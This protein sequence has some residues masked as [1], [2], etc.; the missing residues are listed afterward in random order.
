VPSTCVSCPLCDNEPAAAGDDETTSSSDVGLMSLPVSTD[1]ERSS[2]IT[3]SSSSASRRSMPAN[4]NTVIMF[5]L[6]LIV[7]PSCV[8]S[9]Q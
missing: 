4:I 6:A 1:E 5:S 2:V 3:E 9:S 7:V 8:H